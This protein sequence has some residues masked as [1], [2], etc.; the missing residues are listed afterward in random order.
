MK[1]F[2]ALAWA[3]ALVCL[4]GAVQADPDAPPKSRFGIP[5]KTSTALYPERLTRSFYLP[6]R[7]GTKLAVSV[8]L[9]A[10]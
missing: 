4:A 5:A 3:V 8:T 1:S 2:G 10:R 7:D 6:V 9:P